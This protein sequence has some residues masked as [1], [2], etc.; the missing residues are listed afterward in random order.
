MFTRPEIVC[1]VAGNTCWWNLFTDG[2][3][4][5]SETNQKLELSKF[6]TVAIPFYAI[7]DADEKGGGDVRGLDWGREGVPGLPAGPEAAGGQ[8]PGVGG[9]G[10]ELGCSRKLDGG[11]LDTSAFGGKVVV[12]NFW[13]TWCVPCIEEN[14]GLQQIEPATRGERRG[15][16]G[17]L[18]GRRGS[19]A[20]AAVPQEA[21]HGLP[22]GRSGSEA[23][24]KQYGLGESLPVTNRLRPLGETGEAVRRIHFGGRSAGG[25]STGALISTAPP[26]AVSL[27]SRASSTTPRTA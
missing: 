12:V 2:T 15:G 17:D 27:P 25:G 11:A 21:T 1:G 5:A 22:G 10:P 20:R 13:A 26:A 18:H 8:G 19:G 7:L 9:Q 14:S 16:A 4:P 3:T 23:I 24:S 6:H